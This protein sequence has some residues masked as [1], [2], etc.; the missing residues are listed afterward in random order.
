MRIPAFGQYVFAAT[1]VALGVV[2]VMRADFVP[3]WAPVPKDVPAREV[4]IYA[5]AIVSVGCG[6]GLMW[7]R[8]APLAARVLLAALVLWLVAFRVR[9]IV[10]APGAFGA[11]DGCAET[12]VIVA[13]AWALC[14][15]HVRFARALF[16][17]ALVAFGLAHFLYVDETASLVPGWLPAHVPIAYVTGAA[18]LAAGA[19]V[20][21][22]VLARIAA[23]LSALQIGLF[24]ALVWI[25]IIAA[26]GANAFQ[27]S[28]L[29][30]SVALTAAAWVVADS[31]SFTPS[32]T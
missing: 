26:G 22:G 19:A 27:W 24:T 21:S 7:P 15:R 12:A 30:I 25:P 9:T 11:W 31:Y 6:L 17:L 1:F 18:F 20:L 28:E 4:L 3:V 5:C 32:R 29:G 8:T 2:G 10:H 16:G 23:A 14:R 13:A